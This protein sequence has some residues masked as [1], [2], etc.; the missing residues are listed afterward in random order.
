MI[1]KPTCVNLKLNLCNRY[2]N[3][4]NLRTMKH[5][6]FLVTML[7]FIGCNT[8]EKDLLGLENS[9]LKSASS[10]S[11]SVSE[12]VFNLDYQQQ[13][14]T[15]D[16]IADKSVVWEPV[17]Y[18]SYVTVASQTASSIT[19]NVA[20]NNYFLGP[21]STTVFIRDKNGIQPN[22]EIQIN[23]HYDTKP[24]TVNP[25]DAGITSKLFWDGNAVNAQ[26]KMTNVI[27]AVLKEPENVGNVY[28]SYESAINKYKF[29]I[30]KPESSHRVE[31]HGAPHWQASNNSTIYLGWLSR[32]TFADSNSTNF[33]F[34]QWKAFNNSSLPGGGKYAMLQNY[35]IV[36][37]VENGMY[38][39]E[40]YEANPIYTNPNEPYIGQ[41]YPYYQTN[42]KQLIWSKPTSNFIYKWHSIV[43]KIGLNRDKNLGYIELWINGERQLLGEGIL[44]KP[45]LRFYCRTFDADICETRFGVYGADGIRMINEIAMP[46]AGNTY[47]SVYTPIS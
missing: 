21:R 28:V 4:Q 32:F 31:L 43:L 40:Q 26:T 30:D 38:K 39:L 18:A 41:S 46:R 20:E 16:V 35:P 13:Q 25:S 34:F 22:A 36:F 27:K 44:E 23:Q 6:S 12:N 19:F 11:L 29:T 2:I 8:N 7:I 3:I 1:F 9:N 33:A 14:I 37:K 15:V 47:Q 5:I 42:I 17:I 24:M 10:T 45:Q